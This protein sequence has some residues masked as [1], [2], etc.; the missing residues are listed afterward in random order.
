[1]RCDYIRM[2]EKKRKKGRKKKEVVNVKTNY[3]ISKGEQEQEWMISIWQ[4]VG[5]CYK[6]IVLSNVVRLESGTIIA[7]FHPPTLLLFQRSGFCSSVSFSPRPQ[8]ETKRL[9]SS[10]GGHPRSGLGLLPSFVVVVPPRAK[11]ARC[12]W[13]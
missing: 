4:S 8:L 13:N 2:M 12:R 3:G 10:I 11:F 1:M 5:V 9:D 7:R 6:P